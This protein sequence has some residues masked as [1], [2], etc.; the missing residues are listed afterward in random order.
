[1][2][3]PGCVPEVVAWIGLDWADQRHEIRLAAA[4]STTVESFSVE[5]KPA[6]LHAWVAQLRAR[7]PQ[8]KIAVALEQSRGAA[9]TR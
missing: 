7:F 8:G 4:G 6:A 9:S 3:T 5:Q 2:E 1:M